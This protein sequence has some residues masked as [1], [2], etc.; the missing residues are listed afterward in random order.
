MKQRKYSAL[1]LIEVLIALSMIAIALTALIKAN[2][3]QVRFT[4]IEKN[5]VIGMIIADQ[6][7]QMVRLGLVKL[8]PSIDSTFKTTLFNQ[9]WFWRVHLTTKEPIDTY[10]I[11]ISS[12][13]DG[14]F[15]PVF[16]G[17]QFNVTKAL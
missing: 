17:E 3:D 8:E 2:N 7:L 9:N 14:S 13:Q 5:T 15:T 6:G 4:T 1:T 12:R 16:T 11:S 10:Q